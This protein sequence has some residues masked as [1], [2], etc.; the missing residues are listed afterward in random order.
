MNLTPT[1]WQ[2]L[3]LAYAVPLTLDEDPEAIEALVA[4]GFLAHDNTMFLRLTIYVLTDAGR[5]ALERRGPQPSTF[6]RSQTSLA[7]SA[8]N[9]R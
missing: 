4:A 5:D 6:L 8:S 7:A 1:H 2:L 3:E 9:S